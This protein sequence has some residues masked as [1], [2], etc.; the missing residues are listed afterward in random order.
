M[1]NQE[2]IKP[3][4]QS[5][6]ITIS[7][8]SDLQKHL[9]LDKLDAQERSERSRRYRKDSDSDDS[10]SGSSINV[11]K[12]I[13]TNRKSSSED[14]SLDSN[15]NR[16]SRRQSYEK[17]DRYENSSYRK[18]AKERLSYHS[19]SS[20]YNSERKDRELDP[21]AYKERSP[22]ESIDR[23]EDARDKL[24]ARKRKYRESERKSRSRS[25]SRSRENTSRRDRDPTRSDRRDGKRQI[26]NWLQ[27]DNISK[28][29]L[30]KDNDKLAKRAAKFG[31]LSRDNSKRELYNDEST[32]PDS[33]AAMKNEKYDR[34]KETDSEDE[35]NNNS[36]ERGKEYSES[37]VSE[38]DSNKD[39]DDFS[40]DESI[41]LDV[42]KIR[43]SGDDRRE[44]RKT[45]EDLKSSI[46]YN[47]LPVE[48]ELLPDYDSSSRSSSK[49]AQN[50]NLERSQ[51]SNQKS[52]SSL[53]S[54][55]NKMDSSNTADLSRGLSIH[56]GDDDIMD[57]MDA[58]LND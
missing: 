1:K 19:S 3:E 13:H 25:R 20:R 49:Q 36:K 45:I 8:N 27:L 42:S 4:K 56:A 26:A 28:E 12:T 44:S 9:D 54:I 24:N 18:S 30:E 55:L 2:Y 17:D 6:Q 41:E 33:A 34:Y 10:S 32:R 51:L 39:T 11:R 38:S 50:D 7:N 16:N 22:Y 23:K 31:K 43:K 15:S 35:Y 29:D 53:G 40:S 37:D 57:E 14:S 58:L 21:R 46:D 47:N 48:E 52:T 5:V